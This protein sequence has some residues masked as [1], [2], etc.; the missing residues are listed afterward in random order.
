MVN[1]HHPSFFYKHLEDIGEQWFAEEMETPRDYFIRSSLNNKYGLATSIS[2]V[3]V[4][5]I[6]Q[7]KRTPSHCEGKQTYCAF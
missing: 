1:C 5:L 2:A 6:R 7:V 3:Q 4:I